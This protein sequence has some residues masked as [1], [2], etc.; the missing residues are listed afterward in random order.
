MPWTKRRPEG[1]LQRRPKEHAGRPRALNPVRD[2]V[3]DPVP[4]PVPDW[5]PRP[6]PVRSAL[7]LALAALLAAAAH[8][9]QQPPPANLPPS[10]APGLPAPAAPQVQPRFLVVIDAAHGGADTGARISDRLIEKDL[11][12]SLSVR[13]RS[14]LNARGI[15]VITT[16]ES[17]QQLTPLARAQA[18]NHAAGS[19]CVL[20][21][22][23]ATGSGIHL[24]NSSLAPAARSSF[25]PWQSAQAAYVT[26]S[27]RLSSDINSAMVHAA[28]P[29]VLGRTSLQ[30]MDSLTC[31]AVAVEVTPLPAAGSSPATPLSDP[32]YQRRLIDALAAAITQWRDDWRQQP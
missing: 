10:P 3:P 25:L 12:L 15:P 11:V 2:S 5:V 24:Y 16:R 20:L 17:D 32:V 6:A 22:A 13:L 19:A 26:Q 8:A 28:I 30:P 4:A 1:R 7:L 29:V 27:M 21:H 14:I 9:Q 31:P 23:T 18:I